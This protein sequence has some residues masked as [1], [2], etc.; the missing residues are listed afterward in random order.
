MILELETDTTRYVWAKYFAGMSF[1]M[2]DHVSVIK[3][4]QNIVSAAVQGR[5][6]WQSQ[7][8]FL[9]QSI[10]GADVYILSPIMMG[11]SVRYEVSG[12]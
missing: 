10:E 2:Q 12:L 8:I 11:R 7:D 4:A 9:P 6:E 3:G 5:I 1:V